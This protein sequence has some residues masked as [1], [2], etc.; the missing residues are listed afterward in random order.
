MAFDSTAPAMGYVA[1][2]IDAT[3]QY[4]AASPGRALLLGIFYTPILIVVL[5]ILKQL[6]S[7]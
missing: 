1:A 3:Q 6:V 4:V 5:N 2:F 7:V